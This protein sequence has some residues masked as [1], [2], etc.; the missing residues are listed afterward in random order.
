MHY[1]I[2]EEEE[3]EDSRESNVMFR[4]TNLN[5][6]FQWSFGYRMTTS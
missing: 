3:E 2:P 4:S 5:Q 6:N 1:L